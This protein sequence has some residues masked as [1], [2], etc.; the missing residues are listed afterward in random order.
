MKRTWMKSVI[1]LI[2]VCVLF[3]GCADKERLAELEKVKVTLEMEN[4][5][6]K[7]DLSQA[8]G[9]LKTKEADVVN[10]QQQLL[11]A[12]TEPQKVKTS[13]KTT[14]KPAKKAVKKHS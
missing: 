13:T 4:G 7:Q 12:Q 2:G 11:A 5:K 9:L 8:S 1:V 3:C 6:L 10:L 14:A